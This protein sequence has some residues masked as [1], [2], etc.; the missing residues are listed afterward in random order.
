M[1][2]VQ[3]SEEPISREE[4][5]AYAGRWVAIADGRVAGV[6]ETAMA[7]ENLGRR[8]P[9]NDKLEITFVE[10]SEGEL[11][12]RHNLIERLADIFRRHDQ[13]VYLVGGSVRDMLLG[14]SC[15]DL[16]FAVPERAISLAYKVADHLHVPVFVLDRERDTGRVII[17]DEGMT[18]DFAG[19]RGQDIEA[20]LRARDFTINSIA[21][22]IAAQRSS[23]LIDPCHGRRDLEG[24]IIRQAHER[25]ISDD[26]VRAMRALRFAQ[27]MNFSIEAS[28]YTAV[29]ESGPLLDQVSVERIRDE[30]ILIIGGDNPDQALHMLD[31]HALL[32]SVL[33]E[34]ADLEDIA[35]SAPHRESVLPHTI[36][37]LAVLP[38]VE[39]VL[40]DGII[41]TGP[42]S[43]SIEKELGRYRE[44]L[45]EHF[46]RPVQGPV[47]G[48]LL[49]RLGAIF[50]DSG[51]NLTK[52]VEE[53]GRIRFFGHEKVGARIAANRLRKLH[54][55]KQA[56]D[57]IYDIVLG[58]M[59]P[60]NLANEKSV[61]RR[62]IYRFFKKHGSAGLDIGLLS[63]ADYLATHGGTGDEGNWTRLLDVVDQLFDHYLNHFEETIQPAPLVR[64]KELMDE[65]EM[66]PGP[67]VGRLLRM[68]EEA[69][70]AGEISSIEEAKSFAKKA[71]ASETHKE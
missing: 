60:L 46:A 56:V 66:E 6:G 15:K 47:N 50:H 11:L 5:N 17:P 63:I 53:D 70:A 35:Q 25:S 16:D 45:R 12:R 21:L 40:L 38:L 65:F 3:P 32:P 54:F 39:T 10:L 62:A 27:Q 14:R 29:R 42:A 59:R 52:S 4:L 36:S 68:I 33:P 43:S 44:S 67:D 49:L 18:L 19:F 31:D 48:R 58:H 26:P 22:P 7:A 55:S 20:D 8:Y 24:K 61:T 30:L 13:P 64:G 2:D 51:K 69:Q 34:I 9:I 57:H 41:T 71:L 23:S 1:T 37:V 28:T